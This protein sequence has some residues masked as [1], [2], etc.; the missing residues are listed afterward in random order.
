[1]TD[2]T[3][4]L[5]VIRHGEPASDDRLTQAGADEA[6]ATAHALLSR[7]LVP[8]RIVSSTP[9]RA[10]MTT[11]IIKHILSPDGTVPVQRENL[12]DMNSRVFNI[13]DFI[14]RHRALTG[15]TLLSGHAETM[16]CFAASL[17]SP[18]D[19]A[20]LFAIL[21]ENRFLRVVDAGIETL[22]FLPKCGDAIIMTQVTGDNPRYMRDVVDDWTLSGYIADGVFIT[23]PDNDLSCKL[24]GEKTRRNAPLPALYYRTPR[25]R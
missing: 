19:C 14:K 12:L 20:R 21:P 1:M 3:A 25:P 22:R 10:R 23:P 4:T 5:I 9:K 8:G 16:D 18:G 2:T 7:N 15:V 24:T 13:A 11:H 6:R 17:L